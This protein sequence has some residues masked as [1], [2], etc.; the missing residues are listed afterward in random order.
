M[1][2]AIFSDVHGNLTSLETVLQDIHEHQP[3]EIVF[4]GDLCAFGPRP[5]DCVAL[6]Q[7][8]DHIAAVYGNTDEWIDG[9]P[10]LSEDVEEEER[11]RRRHVDE[12]VSWTR[13]TLSAE[14]RAWLRE[15]PFH[16]RVSPSVNPHDD[17][18][19][20]HANPRDV[21]QVIFPPEDRQKELYGKIRQPD[22][23]L[24]LI[25]Q[26]TV[27][28]VLAF[29]HLHIPSIRTWQ[30][31]TLVNVSSVSMPGDGDPRAKYALLTWDGSQ[32][33]I[34]H[35]RVAWDAT[36]EIAAYRSAQP[37]GWEDA[38][39]QLEDEGMVRQNV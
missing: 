29:G 17:L 4:A 39:A 19:I 28:G 22:N 35:H 20:V 21:N 30:D 15:L 23:D 38:V 25:L 24:T 9:P 6:L 11:E 2:I 13:E 37:P 27:A 12:V 1:R 31:I 36:A 18:L 14:Q 32:W 33:T 8:Q 7:E 10:L 16:R 26:N 34:E 3:D 5:Q